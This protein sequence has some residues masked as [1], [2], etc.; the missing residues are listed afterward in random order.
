MAEERMDMDIVNTIGTEVTKTVQ[1]PFKKNPVFRDQIHV[2]V[3]VTD[4]GVDILINGKVATTVTEVLDPDSELKFTHGQWDVT[5]KA[6]RGQALNIRIRGG[7]QQLRYNLLVLA[8]TITK[9][10]VDG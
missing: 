3:A 1:G 8:H 10:V 9:V 7:E 6:Y 5:S 2:R 4:A